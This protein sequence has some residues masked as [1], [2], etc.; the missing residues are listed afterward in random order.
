VKT[1]CL[2]LE[3]TETH[4]EC[5]HVQAFDDGRVVGSN[6]NSAMEHLFNQVGIFRRSNIDPESIKLTLRDED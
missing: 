6:L 5:E 4:R 2:V 1:K 3:W